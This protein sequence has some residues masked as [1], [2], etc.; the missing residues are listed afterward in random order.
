MPQLISAQKAC[1][2]ALAQ[3]IAA[4]LAAQGNPDVVVSQ[5]WPQASKALPRRAIT[6]LEA[7]E[8]QRELTQASVTLENVRTSTTADY[9]VQAYNARLPM[10]IDIWASS[11]VERDDLIARLDDMLN[12]GCSQLPGV[13]N[14][15]AFSEGVTLPMGANTI[16]PSSTSWNGNSMFWFE[17]FV[18]TDTPDSTQRS[19]YRASARGEAQYVYVQTRTLDRLLGINLKLK[20]HEIGAAGSPPSTQLWDIYKVVNAPKSFIYSTGP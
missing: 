8:A 14:P 9:M 20:A 16:S 12:Q 19:E 13:F 15:D 2:N 17:S 1:A 5:H 4:T 11:D 18:E 7:G 6:V 10:Q 3:Y